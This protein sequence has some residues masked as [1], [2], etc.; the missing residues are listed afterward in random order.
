MLVVVGN[1]EKNAEGFIPAQIFTPK[2]VLKVSEWFQNYLM[3]HS[4]VYSWDA[5]TFRDAF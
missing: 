3:E 4:Q 5:H 2:N 1:G